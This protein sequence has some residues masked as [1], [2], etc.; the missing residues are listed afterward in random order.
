MWS[1]ILASYFGGVDSTVL[2]ELDRRISVLA[3]ID[4]C[5]WRYRVTNVAD[6]GLN[7][8]QRDRLARA[9][10]RLGELLPQVSRLD[11]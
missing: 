8:R 11:F 5:C 10:D 9:A 6:D 1:E 7:E 3:E 4:H 2:T